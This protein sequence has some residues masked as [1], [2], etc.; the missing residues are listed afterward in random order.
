MKS[1]NRFSWCDY[2]V[3]KKLHPIVTESSITGRN[4]NISL[5]FTGQSDFALPKKIKI[6]FT[7]CFITKVP[8]KPELQQSALKSLIR[9]W[10]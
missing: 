9:Y 3:T 1:I 5:V 8:N 6:N 2:L 10:L 7:H 4:L